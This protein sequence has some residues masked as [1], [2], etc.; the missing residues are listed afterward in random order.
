MSDYMRITWAEVR[1]GDVLRHENGDRLTVEKVETRYVQVRDGWMAGFLVADQWRATAALT[2]A[3]FTPHRKVEPLPTKPGAYLDKD[4]VLC[5]R[6]SEEQAMGSVV[7]YMPEA[8][9]PA[10]RWVKS[11]EMEPRGPF[12]RLV[13]MPTREQ[14]LEAVRYKTTAGDTTDAVMALLSGGG[15]GMKSLDQIVNDLY[16]IA[17]YVKPHDKGL[18]DEIGDLAEDLGRISD[19]PREAISQV[20]E[21][22]EA[23]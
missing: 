13:P 16:S 4:G 6:Q 10:G 15:V 7:W 1:P 12:T 21:A 11:E 20:D 3:G 18:Y 14:V 9:G 22:G 17:G 23:R 5:V 8:G 19:A 2:R